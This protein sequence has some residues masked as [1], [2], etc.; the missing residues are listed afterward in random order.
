MPYV[1]ALHRHWL[2]GFV[3]GAKRSV[4]AHCHERGVKLV[5]QILQPTPWLSPNHT[6]DDLVW[7]SLH[8]DVARL[9]QQPHE[10]QQP[11]AD[12]AT[13]ASGV[14]RAADGASA[15]NASAADAY[16]LLVY[17]L[18]SRKFTLPST[19]IASRLETQ[20]G[21]RVRVYSGRESLEATIRLF[22]HAKAVVLYH[23]AALT[24]LVFSLSRTCVVELTPFMDAN[25]TQPGLLWCNRMQLWNPMLTCHSYIVP[26][27][28]I[29]NA[30]PTKKL[31]DG[32]TMRKKVDFFGNLASVD[33]QLTDFDKVAAVAKRCLEGIPAPP[34]PAWI[35]ERLV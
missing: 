16:A 4:V 28:Q 25:N 9:L 35:G 34:P 22:A 17:R 5:P 13:A 19:D 21:M 10:Q 1:A 20:M 2:R 6:A 15:S 27:E 31:H 26:R 23:G 11:Q 18:G 3:D 12:G 24:N 14:E 32:A 30:N 29:L 7:R 33:V 8:L